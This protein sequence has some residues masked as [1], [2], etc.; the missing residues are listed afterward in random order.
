M[1]TVSIIIRLQSKNPPHVQTRVLSRF[2]ELNDNERLESI[3]L[4]NKDGQ[5]EAF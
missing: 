5:L 1:K 3:A 4:V 2:I